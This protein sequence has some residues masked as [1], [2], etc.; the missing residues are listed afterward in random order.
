MTLF[1]FAEP[2][3]QA[4]SDCRSLLK[5]SVLMTTLSPQGKEMCLE[6]F[7]GRRLPLHSPVLTSG[8]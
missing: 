2:N 8:P 3:L 7:S 1:V 6:M 4:A 5:V